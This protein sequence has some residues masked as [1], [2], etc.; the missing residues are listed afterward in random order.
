VLDY[1]K[2]LP[3]R[4]DLWDA[5]ELGRTERALAL[6]PGAEVN[7]GLRGTSPGVLLRLASGCGNRTLVTALLEQGADPT[8]RTEYGANAIDVARE[9]GHDEIVS[10][11]ERHGEAR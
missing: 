3:D 11:L 1:F 8:L 9:R 6:L 10:L 2:S 4:L 5:I 7:A